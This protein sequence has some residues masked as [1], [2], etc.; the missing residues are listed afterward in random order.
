MIIARAVF[1]GQG[2]DEGRRREREGWRKKGRRENA[3]SF[4][5]CDE[6]DER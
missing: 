1:G 2:R 3:L 6:D 4:Q 5:L